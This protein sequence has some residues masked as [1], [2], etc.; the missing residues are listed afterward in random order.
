MWTLSKVLDVMVIYE[1]IKY[2]I[3]LQVLHTSKISEQL[4]SD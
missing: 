2:S 3:N 4:T 1:H